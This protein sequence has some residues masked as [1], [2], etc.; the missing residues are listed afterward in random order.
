MSL[1]KITRDIFCHSKENFQELCMQVFAYQYKHNLVY[2]KY[3]NAVKKVAEI[4]QITN[5]PFLPIQF[6]KNHKIQCTDNAGKLPTPQLIFES[7]GTTG[8]TTSTHYINDKIIYETSLFTHFESFFGPPQS[9]VILALLP[10]YMEKGNSS[11]V[12]MVQQLMDKSKMP[13]NDFFL[14]NHL[15]LFHTLQK[16]EREGKKTILIGVTYALIDFAQAYPIQL[17]NTIVIETGGMKGRK[18]E[19]IKEEVHLILKKQWGLPAVATEY[20]M[21]ELLS[22]AY[23]LKD[24]ILSTPHWMKM[25]IRE[26]NDPF[27]ISTVG[28]GALNIIDLANINSCSFIASDDIGEV[29]EDASFEIL[30]R[31]DSSDI[32]G[33]SLL[34]T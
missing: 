1:T 25:L 11:L 2:Q 24:G 18:E 32:R 14:Y 21:T 17:K 29:Y 20:G 9:F 16:L 3:V 27:H 5:I 12:Y 34:Y 13:E 28:K 10:S 22:Q 33:C 6:F 23:S 7:S 8:T 4:Q 15:E 31:L 30:G 26:V 19:M